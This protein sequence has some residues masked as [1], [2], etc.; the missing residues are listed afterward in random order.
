[1][2]KD[3]TECSGESVIKKGIRRYCFCFPAFRKLKINLEMNEIWRER[4]RKREELQLGSVDYFLVRYI[5]F[6]PKLIIET[7]R[8]QLS[9]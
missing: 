8:S 9:R 5:V 7:K 2:S 3:H 6:G 4:E 1:M